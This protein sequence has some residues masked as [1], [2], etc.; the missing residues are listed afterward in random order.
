MGVCFGSCCMWALRAVSV[1]HNLL[2][3]FAAGRLLLPVARVLVGEVG[4]RC[5]QLCEGATMKLVMALAWLFGKAYRRR[6]T[7]RRECA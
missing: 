6:Y 3:T 2:L 5:A 4:V 1:S 7:V